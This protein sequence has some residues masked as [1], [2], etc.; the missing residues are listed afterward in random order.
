MIV[1]EL[2]SLLAA[3]LPSIGSILSQR[4]PTVRRYLAGLRV[5]SAR[6]LVTIQLLTWQHVQLGID[7]RVDCMDQL[8]YIFM[9]Y[10]QRLTKIRYW[11]DQLIESESC[12]LLHWVHLMR[13]IIDRWQRT[14]WT[15]RQTVNRCQST[16]AMT[17][18]VLLF[19]TYKPRL[20]RLI[21]G[22]CC[23][24]YRQ[25]ATSAVGS[26]AIQPKSYAPRRWYLRPISPAAW[27]RHM[28]ATGSGLLKVGW[29]PF[30]CMKPYWFDG[31]NTFL[32]QKSPHYSSPQI[33]NPHRLSLIGHVYGTLHSTIGHW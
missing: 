5:D 20:M 10:N 33:S 22:F 15:M 12:Y 3:E 21:T 16:R 24:V 4:L 30:A 31:F 7:H 26:L 29:K 14:A 27:N 9:S 13:W 11:A 32:T 1:F 18:Q 23:N 17:L 19:W 28:D 2:C 6:I 8:K 25:L